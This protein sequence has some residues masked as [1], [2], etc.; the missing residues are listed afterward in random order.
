MITRLMISLRKAA[1]SP[2]PAWSMG[3]TTVTR[4]PG[5]EMCT[6]RFAS[7]RD[8]LNGR[9]DDTLQSPISPGA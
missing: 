2:G 6:I 9:D 7:N 1:H 4:D 5:R 3:E 8:A